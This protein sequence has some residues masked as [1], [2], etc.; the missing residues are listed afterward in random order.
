MFKLNYN[1]LGSEGWVMRV[2]TLKT[3]MH[4][5]KK[6]FVWKSKVFYYWFYTFSVGYLT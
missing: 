6:G 2:D 5:R 3:H 1:L 4:A